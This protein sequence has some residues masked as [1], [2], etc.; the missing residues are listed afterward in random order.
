MGGEEEAKSPMNSQHVQIRLK[1]NNVIIF[2]RSIQRARKGGGS[3]DDD[4]EDEDDDD[5]DYD[6]CCYCC[7]CCCRCCCLAYGAADAVNSSGFGTHG[8]ADAVSS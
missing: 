5:Y 2:Q 8:A 3:P 4:D 1:D 7:C 6:C